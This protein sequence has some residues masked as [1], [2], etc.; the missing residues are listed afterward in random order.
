VADAGSQQILDLLNQPSAELRADGLVLA[1]ALRRA[2]KRRYGL[3]LQSGFDALADMRQ[4]MRSLRAQ[5][6]AVETASPSKQDVLDALDELDRSF[7]SLEHG[8]SHGMT[9]KAARRI[10]RAKKLGKG[11]KKALAS[12]VEG[13]SA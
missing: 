3:P 4:H 8:L 10:K 2:P 6:A 13:L 5:I 11:A 12:A 7:G 9:R 1:K